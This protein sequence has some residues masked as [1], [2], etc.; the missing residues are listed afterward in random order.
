MPELRISGQ[1][2]VPS[3]IYFCQIPRAGGR[4]V[5][6]AFR[7]AGY[8]DSY[9]ILGNS[10][11][12]PNYFEILAHY[13]QKGEKPPRSFAIVRHP[14]RRLE[15]AFFYRRRARNPSDMFDQLRNMRTQDFYTRWQNAIRPAHDMVL[16]RTTILKYEDGL[17]ACLRRL[18]D[19]SMVGSAL[20]VESRA[21]G[22]REPLDWSKAPADIVEQIMG[23]YA[24]DYYHFD[25]AL[26]P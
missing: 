25:Y 18:F 19:T 5:L 7:A 9:E 3:P 14:M 11:T 26:Y 1:K 17:N 13:R 4:A 15:S 8:R 16:E 23:L 6:K 22:K 21:G 20:K 2:G 24:A 10:V 12:H